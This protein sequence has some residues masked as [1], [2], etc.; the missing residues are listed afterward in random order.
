MNTNVSRLDFL[1]TARIRNE[2]FGQFG[3][4]TVGHHPAHY[5]TAE[6]VEDHVEIKA[7]PLR[8]AE[9]FRDIPAPELVG[10]GGQQFRLRVRRMH[11]LVAALTRLALA[12]QNSVHSANRAMITAFVEQRVDH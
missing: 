4:L 12:F 1:F 2:P 9:Q 11:E 6:D 3:T 10:T 7:G 5:I 8:R